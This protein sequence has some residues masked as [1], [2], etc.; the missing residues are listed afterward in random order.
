MKKL[1]LI[2]LCVPLI[3]WGQEY[4]Y[5]VNSNKTNFYSRPDNGHK[6]NSYLL[7]G[8][9]ITCSSFKKDGFSLCSYTNKRNKTNKGYIKIQDFL[10]PEEYY[11]SEFKT[12]NMHFGSLL[13]WSVD[14]DSDT[15][16]NYTEFFE[17][18]FENSNGD[19]DIVFKGSGSFDWMIMDYNMTDIHTAN[20]K[21][22]LL[23][24]IKSDYPITGYYNYSFVIDDNGEKYLS[25]LESFDEYLFE[26]K[27]DDIKKN[28]FSLINENCQNIITN[29][30]FKNYWNMENQEHSKI[31]PNNV[32]IKTCS[33]NQYSKIYFQTSFPDGWVDN[34]EITFYMKDDHLIYAE[35]IEDK[36]DDKDIFYIYSMDSGYFC[37]L[38]SYG[39]KMSDWLG[40]NPV[41]KYLDF[42]KTIIK[43]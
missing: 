11:L 38:D 28:D 2:L 7:K 33:G 25:E 30:F 40:G 22:Y 4:S 31:E 42:V 6:L 17:F 9:K 21:E 23:D 43:N 37:V 27:I 32:L 15:I 36:D 34:I 29:H 19:T 20:S 16:R 3:G 41:D 8:D 18:T 26:K 10:D 13:R 35:M 12:S 14:D 39:D 24:I 5:I 1:L